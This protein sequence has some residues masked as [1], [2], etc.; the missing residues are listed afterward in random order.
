MAPAPLAPAV[1]LAIEPR[2]ALAL[3]EPDAVHG[4]GSGSPQRA[5]VQRA[6]VFDGIALGAGA[7]A[8]AAGRRVRARA[9]RLP[10][11][12]ERMRG[13]FLRDLDRAASQRTFGVDRCNAKAANAT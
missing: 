7:C 5:D 1:S 12:A 8:H 9:D 2:S 4:E 13:V 3:R 11:V 10:A 6:V